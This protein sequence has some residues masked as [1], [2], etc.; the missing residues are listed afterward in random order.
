M[1]RT[2]RTASSA[3]G[4]TMILADNKTENNLQGKSSVSCVRPS[5]ICS[6]LQ[7]HSSTVVVVWGRAFSLTWYCFRGALSA[8]FHCVVLYSLY[9]AVKI[10]RQY[11]F[12]VRSHPR[13]L[14]RSR[15]FTYCKPPG[16]NTTTS[17]VASLPVPILSRH[18]MCHCQGHP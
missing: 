14:R 12:M 10:P 7:Q 3:P 4:A 8:K 18:R 17:F 16:R 5:A 13:H 9:K 2:F 15:G 1:G 11:A 6:S